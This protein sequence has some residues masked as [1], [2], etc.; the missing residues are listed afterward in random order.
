[1][2][3][4]LLDGLAKPRPRAARVDPPR[5]ALLEQL[6]RIWLS[7][8]GER[9]PLAARASMVVGE[10]V[11]RDPEQPRQRSLGR[12]VVGRATFEGAGE[13]LRGEVV[14]ECSPY[15]PAEVPVDRAVVALEDEREELR[16]RHRVCEDG[17]VGRF[18]LIHHPQFP[19]AAGSVHGRLT[20]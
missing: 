14:G 12:P 9:S 11:N 17:A 10:E 1:M 15:V 2:V 7:E 13:R 20:W 5:G 6:E 19:A 16:L 8:R 18:T 4:Q 3:V